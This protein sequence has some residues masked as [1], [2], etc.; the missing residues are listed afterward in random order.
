MATPWN[1]IVV[2]G[3][4][5]GL[6]AAQSARQ[7]EAP[8]LVRERPRRPQGP[9]R[10]GRTSRARWVAPTSASETVGTSR[11][12]ASTEPSGHPYASRVRARV[13]PEAGRAGLI[14]GASGIGSR[15]DEVPG[16]LVDPARLRDGTVLGGDRC[17]ACGAGIPVGRL[18]HEV[19]HGPAAPRAAQ[20]RL[21][22]SPASG[23]LPGTAPRCSPRGSPRPVHTSGRVRRRVFSR[24]C[25][26]RRAIR[27]SMADLE[28]VEASESGGVIRFTQAGT[29]L[30][31]LCST[32]RE[33]R[34]RRGRD[35]RDQTSG[36]RCRSVP[37]LARRRHG[38]DGHVRA[39]DR[40]VRGR[41]TTPIAGE[42]IRE[43]QLVR[44]LRAC[45]AGTECRDRPPVDRCPRTRFGAVK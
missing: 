44:V 26:A 17:P 15:A 21:S 42:A 7:E 20:P 10:T 28:R 23:G 8:V 14:T 45:G 37:G 39:R 31:D 19:L 22:P 12:T 40:G 30:D 27:R 25:T 2:V 24:R 4:N 18:Q 32:R 9:S 38:W 34:I 35:G 36:L 13:V 11:S 43:K 33:G 1:V 6:W 29:R 41:V 5:A 3:R 16:P